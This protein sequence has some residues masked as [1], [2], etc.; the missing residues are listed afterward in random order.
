[1]ARLYLFGEGETELTFAFKLLNRRLADFG[2]YLHH[3]TGISHARKRGRPLRGGG[4]NY[5][6][7]RNDI[8]RFLA[9]EKAETCSSQR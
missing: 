4:R 9:Q 6:A 8:S 7:M 5:E 2:V 1:M 3:P